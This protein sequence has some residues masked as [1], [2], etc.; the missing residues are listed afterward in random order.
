M[1]NEMLNYYG[2]E[3]LKE[4]GE[5]RGY[6]NLKDAERCLIESYEEDVLWDE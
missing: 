3:T 1:I 2:F 6:F 5:S 4:Y